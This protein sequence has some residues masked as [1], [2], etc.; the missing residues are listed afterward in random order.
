[1]NKLLSF[2]QL[3]FIGIFFSGNLLI[4]AQEVISSD[5]T[6]FDQG[7]GSLS[8]TVGELT[9][10]TFSDS[11]GILTQGF[12]QSKFLVFFISES[13]QPGLVVKV[14]P[15]PAAFSVSVNVQNERPGN[16]YVKLYD[17]AGKILLNDKLLLPDT[18][19]KLSH[20]PNATYFLKIYSDQDEI[21]SF[22]IIK[23]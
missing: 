8:S 21:K 5:G 18:E 2:K 20:L 19:I 3:V 13:F 10:E 6:F 7:N 4:N 12:Q 14:Y 23:Q 15:N 16:F 17:I 22:K 1:M 9:T 11:S